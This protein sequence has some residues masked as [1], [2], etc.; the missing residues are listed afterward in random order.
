MTLILRASD[1]LTVAEIPWDTK[2]HTGCPEI[3]VHGDRV[4]I[5]DYNE[6]DGKDPSY[7]ET[8]VSVHV[9]PTEVVVDVEW[10]YADAIVKLANEIKA[11]KQVK[12]G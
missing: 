12:V 11:H 1:G 4:Y 3:V 9:I 6:W 5:Y 10:R 7:T 2:T 8:C